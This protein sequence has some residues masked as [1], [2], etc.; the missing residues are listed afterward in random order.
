MKQN[1]RRRHLRPRPSRSQINQQMRR[2]RSLLNLFRTELLLE[3]Q[4]EKP[5]SGHL[6]FVHDRIGEIND[7]I[8]SLGQQ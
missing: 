2:M 1:R 3:T 4:Q 5:H 6:R 8:A 7:Q